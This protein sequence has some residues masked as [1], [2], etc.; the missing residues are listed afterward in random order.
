MKDKAVL[1]AVIWILGL[2]SVQGAKDWPVTEVNKIGYDPAYYDVFKAAGFDSVRFFVKQGVDPLH[3]REAIDGAINRGLPVVITGFTGRVHGKESFVQY[4]RNFAKLYQMYPKELVFEI[5]NEPQMAGHP[6][7][8]EY[9]VELMGWL[10]DAIVAIR[11]TNPTRVIAVGGPSH[12]HADMLVKYV[13]PEYLNYRLP[14]GTG[15]EEDDNIWGIFHCYNPQGWSH[16]QNMKSL[17]E[18][19]PDWKGEISEKLDLGHQWAQTHGKKV[20][21]SEWGTRLHNP[22]EDMLEVLGF[23]KKEAAKRDIDWM[24]YCG[25][26]NN[27]WTFALY[28]SEW[29]FE[30][31]A[32]LVEVLTGE[33]P[34][35]M[36]LPTNQI[37]NSAFMMDTEHWYSNGHV[38]LGTAD[39]QGVD[40]STALRCMVMF[41]WPQEPMIYQETKP[42][43]RFYSLGFYLLQLRQGNTYSI[44]FYAKTTNKTTLRVQLEEVVDDYLAVSFLPGESLQ[45]INEQSEEVDN[46][47]IVLWRSEPV[48]IDSDLKKYELTYVHETESVANARFSIIFSDRHSEVILDDIKLVGAR[49]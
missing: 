30:K 10:G 5:M 45:P 47:D 40:G 34:K 16:S 27:A 2:A 8:P 18:V 29:G 3:Y 9:D 44:S 35:L 26:F 37:N 17:I 6:N 36:T 20:L 49:P 25:V 13:T 11:E 33:A 41:V 14:D 12:N 38:T 15:F 19:N 42:E 48:E 31:T 39:G 43:W 7:E 46:N 28:N 21:L 23:M 22:R 24:Y 4:W 32:D 1:F